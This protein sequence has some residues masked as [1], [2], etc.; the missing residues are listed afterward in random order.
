MYFR[1]PGAREAE[2][3]SM[4]QQYSLEDSSGSPAKLTTL[5]LND[6]PPGI[7]VWG[8]QRLVQAS[9]TRIVGITRGRIVIVFL[10]FG[11]GIDYPSV[12]HKSSLNRGIPRRSSMSDPRDCSLIHRSRRLLPRRRQPL[13]N[14]GS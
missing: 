9:I 1:Q 12:T 6:T 7:R 2:Q 4:H 11:P 14:P 5:S 13:E 10:V 8:S 3:A